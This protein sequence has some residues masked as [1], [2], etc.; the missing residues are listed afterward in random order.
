MMFRRLNR[1]NED[2]NVEY[3]KISTLL[4]IMVTL[5]VESVICVIL[6]YGGYLVYCGSFDAGQ[7]VE[8]IGYFSA[9]VSFSPNNVCSV[10]EIQAPWENTNRSVNSGSTNGSHWCRLCGDERRRNS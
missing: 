9:V 10:C 4:N 2:I 1:E 6:G 3:T 7:L 8:Y 5:F